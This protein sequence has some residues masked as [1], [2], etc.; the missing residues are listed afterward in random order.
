MGNQSILVM[1]KLMLNKKGFTLVEMLLCLSVILILSAFSFTYHLPQMSDDEQLTLIVNVLTYAR[2][3]AST[4]K[5]VTDVDVSPHQLHVYSSHLDRDIYLSEG[6]QFLSSHHF[7]YNNTGRIKNA[8]T[9][10][11]KTPH[12]L[13]ALIFQLGSGTFYVE[14][15]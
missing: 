5:E 7:T 10:K 14:E 8:K 9:I 2:M 12:K 13:Y 15:Q 4:K 3:H 1:D 11:L 6:Y